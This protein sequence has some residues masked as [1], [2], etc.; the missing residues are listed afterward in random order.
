M[1]V[2]VMKLIRPLLWCHN[3][4]MDS[5]NPS[6]SSNDKWP[7]E[8]ILNLVSFEQQSDTCEMRKQQ[9][10]QIL[11]SQVCYTNVKVERFSPRNYYSD[12]WTALGF[13]FEENSD[14]KYYWT[15]GGSEKHIG[16]VNQA[17]LSF[18]WWYKWG[19]KKFLVMDPSLK[20]MLKAEF[21]Y[22]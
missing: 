4:V 1:H 11:S 10:M 15:F 16:N 17:W 21:Y 19:S 13:H 9:Q 2:D 8:K 3:K 12:W 18:V 20:S 7:Y 14:W 5:C 6:W 22:L